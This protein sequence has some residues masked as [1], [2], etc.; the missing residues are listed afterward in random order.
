MQMF[1]IRR[2]PEGVMNHEPTD[3]TT[4]PARAAGPV[5]EGSVEDGAAAQDAQAPDEASQEIVRVAA[6]RDEYLDALQRLKAE[7][8]N[9]RKR[10]DRDRQHS[11]EFDGCAR[12]RRDFA[13]RPLP[14]DAARRRRNDDDD[15]PHR[16]A[17]N[18]RHRRS[19]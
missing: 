1:R 12:Q 11:L 13:E 5:V 16:C 14:R 10:N 18:V 19:G 7:F 2:R 8:D 17:G 4:D 9:F 6:E 15:L 3:P